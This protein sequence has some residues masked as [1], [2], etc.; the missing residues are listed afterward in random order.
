M[1]FLPHLACLV[2]LA[3]SHH[4]CSCFDAE[5]GLLYS[6]ELCGVI[7]EM[8]DSSK[9]E[10]MYKKIPI[11]AGNLWPLCA[12]RLWRFCCPSQYRAQEMDGPFLSSK[13]PSIHFAWEIIP[14]FTCNTL[15]MCAKSSILP[16]WQGNVKGTLQDAC[17]KICV[18]PKGTTE[19][20]PAST[21]F[22]LNNQQPPSDTAKGKNLNLLPRL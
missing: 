15:C 11:S 4:Y 12:A 9:Q 21:L 2:A 17:S 13:Y 7:E 3:V 6:W 16:L 8:C 20:R 14:C 22:K 18:L 19:D 5:G 1:M 10:K